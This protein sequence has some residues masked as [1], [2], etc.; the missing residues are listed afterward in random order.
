MYSK[1]LA[2]VL[3][4]PL[5]TIISVFVFI[6]LSL[7]LGVF[8]SLIIFEL[9]IAYTAYKVSTFFNVYKKYKE[10]VKKKKAYHFMKIF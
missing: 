5:F 8:T 4:L 3:T 6:S 7:P 9:S 2:P 1:I 10:V